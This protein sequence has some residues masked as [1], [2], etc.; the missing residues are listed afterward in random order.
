[1]NVVLTCTLAEWW[2]EEMHAFLW[3]VDMG[4]NDGLYTCMLS[5]STALHY[6]LKTVLKIYKDSLM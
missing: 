4:E 1:M 6:A 3:N 5:A 2:Q